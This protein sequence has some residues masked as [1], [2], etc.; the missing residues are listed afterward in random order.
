MK[1]MTGII[2]PIDNPM[3]N[4]LNSENLDLRSSYMNPSTEI[5]IEEDSYVQDHLVC[6]IR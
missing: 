1:I 5:T 3:E 4:Q 2:K 6:F